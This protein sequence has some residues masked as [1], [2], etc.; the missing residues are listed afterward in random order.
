LFHLG[1]AVK[2]ISIVGFGNIFKGDLGIGCYLMDALCQ[3]PLGDTVELSYLG[4][5]LHYAGAYICDMDFAVI[6]GGLCMGGCTGNIHCWDKRTF[7][8]NISWLVEK[9]DSM[10]LLAQALARMELSMLFPEDILFLWIEPG[11]TEGFGMSSE[12]RKA[13]RKT[14]HIIKENLFRRGF[15]PETA[16]RLSSIYQLEVLGTTV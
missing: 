9:S 7:Q 12:M 1:D 16:Y 2:N 13:L 6:A 10:R 11:L 15:L 8:H 4:E 5:N 3:E 14:V